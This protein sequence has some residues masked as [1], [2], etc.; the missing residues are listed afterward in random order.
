M[1]PLRQGVSLTVHPMSPS[2]ASKTASQ[3]S[4]RRRLSRNVVVGAAAV[5]A[6][7]GVDQVT[8]ASVAAELG[9]TAMALYQHVNDKEHLLTLVLDAR[10]ELIEVPSA[11]DAD[12][13]VLLRN[14]HLAIVEAMSH[15]PGLL[16]E[17]THSDQAARLLEGYLQ[18][19][20]AAGF[21]DLGAATAYTGLYY[22]AM[23]AQHPYPAHAAATPAAT[24]P[25]NPAHQ[26][27]A[28]AARALRNATAQK[29]QASAV[30][31]YITGLR[32]QCGSR[33][34]GE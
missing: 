16:T 9:V 2:T 3:P 22:L 11:T 33:R 6:E 23:G 28:R 15:Y 31:A 34:S 4:M 19:L 29:M 14:Y 17:I 30:D 27:T 12:W 5:V 24:P 21:D 1:G 32:N 18:I 7:R 13:H 25:A 26:A 8:M 10:L 20:L